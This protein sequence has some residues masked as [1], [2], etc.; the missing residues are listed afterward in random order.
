MDAIPGPS[1]APLFHKPLGCIEDALESTFG[2]SSPTLEKRLTPPRS[3]GT[4]L[5]VQASD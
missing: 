4:M 2:G 5:T 3:E 1:V